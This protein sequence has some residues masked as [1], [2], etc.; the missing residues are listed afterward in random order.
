MITNRFTQAWYD[1]LIVCRAPYK[2]R[3]V[4]RV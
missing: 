3:L 2:N 1:V 4:S